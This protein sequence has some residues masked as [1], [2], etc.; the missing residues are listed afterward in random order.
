MY[1]GTVELAA[2]MA[3]RSWGTIMRHLLAI[4]TWLLAFF[5]LAL[6]VPC[7]EHGSAEAAE[8]VVFEARHG[9]LRPGQVIDGNSRIQLAAGQRATLISPD[10]IMLTLA[11]PFEGQADDWLAKGGGGVFDVLRELVTKRA[12]GGHAQAGF[13]RGSWGTRRAARPL[14]RRREHRRG[15]VL[16]GGDNRRV[17]ASR[18]EKDQAA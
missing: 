11:G 13:W 16:P 4:K 5:L 7:Y 2:W 17:L 10:G 8:F 6:A 15:L 18:R 9:S 14:G 3:R 1:N 12:T